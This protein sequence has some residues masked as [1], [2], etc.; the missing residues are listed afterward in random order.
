[1]GNQSVLQ[2]AAQFLEEGDSI[3]ISPI[4]NGLIH[5]TF[6]AAT[7][8]ESIVLQALNTRI[9]KN[10]EDIVSNYWQV[11]SYLT[12]HDKGIEIPAPV[13]SL[14]GK[15]LWTDSDGNAWR[16]TQYVENSY[17][18]DTAEN[19][20]AARTVALSFATF[21]QSLTGLDPRNLKTIIPGFHD[22]S[23]RYAQFEESVLNASSERLIQSTHL[24]S[25]FRN[26]KHLVEF[27]ELT[28]NE[29]DFPSRV[30]HHDSKIN[31]ILFN[32]KTHHPICPV[33]LDTVMPGKFFSDLG[34]MIRSMACTVD[35][36]SRDW[37]N[38]GIRP[39]YYRAILEG[40]LQGIDS[41]LTE[42]ELKN[43]HQAGLILIYMQGLR[44]LSDYLNGDIY[45]KTSYPGHNLDRARN[46]FIL[47]EKLE[48]FIYLTSSKS[49]SGNFGK[50]L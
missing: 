21:T 7:A 50:L 46:Q 23:A 48:E 10:P 34:D 36:N 2:A 16:A 49:R 45:Y 32:S 33:D 1:L 29:T 5:Q 14:Y 20:E 38:I 27:Y 26:R 43:I 24:I 3:K 25:E 22:L 44:F 47:L 40:Y 4:G 9:F 41:L 8:N 19:E 17:S 42:A 12:L 18:P 11:Y 35:E 15:L 6:L 30:M 13:S 28:R 39:D 37:E 31:N